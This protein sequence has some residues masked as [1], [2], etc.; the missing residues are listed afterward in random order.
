MALGFRVYKVFGLRNY[1]AW[2]LGSQVKGLRLWVQGVG[3]IGLG[4]RLWGVALAA[5]C[6]KAFHV[7]QEPPVHGC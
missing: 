1:K 7:L 3:F 6:L 4:F 5:P 2:F